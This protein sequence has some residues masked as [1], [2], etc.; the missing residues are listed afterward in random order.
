[1]M[2]G[3]KFRSRFWALLL[4]MAMVFTSGNVPISEVRAEETVSE[5]TKD[6]GFQE[7]SDAPM[8]ES[9][10]KSTEQTA[11]TTE[12][13]SETVLNV[14]EGESTETEAE[15]A[16]QERTTETAEGERT[17]ETVEE[18]A[19][20]IEESVEPATEEQEETE[21]SKE[22]EDQGDSDKSESGKTVTNEFE[23]TGEHGAS[24]DA[25]K[26]EVT[27]FVNKADACYANIK[28]MWYKEYDSYAAAAKEHIKNGG[29]FIAGVGATNLTENADQTKKSVTV[30]VSEG[31]GAILYYINGEAGHDRNQYEHIIVIDPD[32]EPGTVV[33]ETPKKPG[34][35]VAKWWDEKESPNYGK[36]Y[37][38]WAAASEAQ[39]KSWE[40]S[41]DGKQLVTLENKNTSTY[42]AENIYAEG[43]HK[44]A[45]KAV[46]EA[47]TSEAAEAVFTLNA[48]QAGGGSSEEES[49]CIMISE[50]LE[51]ARV[52]EKI[53]LNYADG[54]D[55]SVF[56]DCTVKVNGEDAEGKYTVDSQKH[57]IEFEA[58]LFDDAGVYRILFEKEGYEFSPVYQIVYAADS[59][60]KWDLVWNDEFSGD[61]LDTGKW[62]YQTGNG[63]AYGVSGWGNSEEQIY[64][65]DSNVSVGDGKLTITAKKE[66]DSYTSARLRTVKEEIGA[67]GKAAVGAP[68]KIGTYGR[69][70]S[71][72]KMPEG[73][74][75]WPAFWMLPHDSEYGTWAASGEIDIM[76]A[77]GRLPGEVC[78]TIHYGDKWPNNSSSGK[79]YQFENGE[80]IGQYHIY[81]IEWDPT[82]MRWYVDGELY[83]TVTNWYSVESESGNYPF[84]APFDE[85]FYVLLNMAL[86]GTFD[87]GASS[88][89]V[90]EN[91]VDMDVD[92]VRWYQREGGY[93]DWEITPPATEKDESQT[94]KEL[95]DTADADK[96]F[97]RDNDFS[98]MKVEPYTADGSWD[99]KSGYW[100]PLLIPGNGNGSAEWSKTTK[101]GK[102][103]LKVAVNNVGSQTYSSQMLQY[104]PVVKGYS[105]EISYT[106]YTDAVKQK[107]D[108]SLK[109]GGDGDNGWAV[110]SGNYA[111]SLTTT[112]ATYRHKFTMSAET[113][114][115][116]RFEFNLATSAGNVYL[117]DVYVKLI[118]KI[119]EDEG[120][121]DDKEP[122]ADGNHI[123]NGGFSNGIDSLLYWHWGTA[124][125]KNVVTGV[126]VG[127]ERKAQ[128]KVENNNAVSM[129]QYGLNLLQSDTYVLTFDVDSDAAQDIDLKV[130]DKDGKEVYAE[131][132]KSVPAG[133]SKVKW[134]FVQ[135]EDKTDI[136]G[137]LV[138]TFHCSAKLDNVKLVRTT[139]NNVDYDKVDL[140]PLANG[141]F[142]DGLTGWNIWH[143]GAGWE[144]H[145]VNDQGQLELNQVKIGESATFYCVGIQSPSMSLTKGINYKVKFDY[146]LPAEKTYTLELGGEQREITLQAGTHTYESEVFSGSG[147]GMFALYLGPRQSQEYTLLLD[148]IVVYAD[149]PIKDGYK[150]PVS[151]GQD[152]KAKAGSDVVVKYSGSA[153][154]KSGW[155]EADKKYYLDNVEIAADKVRLETASNRMVIDA[156]LFPDEGV[157]VFWVKA[158]GYTAT[159]V[160]SL[161]VLDASGNLL[162]N[163]NFSDG[164]TGWSF[165][166]ADW[167]SGGSFEVNE[168]G[169]A[170]IEHGYDGG[171]DWHLQLYQDLDY[172]AGDYIVTFDAWAD[173][174]RPV[175]IRLQPDG[176][177]PAFE[178][179][180]SMVVLSTEKKS[181][182]VIWKG[183]AAA[184]AAR[185]DLAMGSMTYD[186]VSA[187]ND[188][189][190]PYKIYLDNIIFRPLTQQDESA[191][192]A[193][194]ASAGAGKAGAEPV[195]VTFTGA[196]DDWKSADKTV[197]VNDIAVDADKVT[198]GGN[199]LVIDASV[200]GEAGRYAVYIAAE[201]FEA[202][203][204]I[205]KNM[206]GADGNRIF[207]GDMNNASLWT[208]YDEDPLNLSRSEIA[209]GVYTLDYTAGYFRDDWNCW[210]TWSSQLKKENISVE[211]GKEYVLRFE[212]STDLE[213][214][215]D[216]LIEYGK[217]GVEGNPQAKAAIRQGEPGIYEVRITPAETRDDF[218]ICY[219]LGPIGDNLQVQGASKV[220]HMLKIDNVTLR[221]AGEDT[222]AAKAQLDACIAEYESLT[223]GDYTD[224]SWSAFEE[225]LAEAKKVQADKDADAA[226]MTDAV[227]RL[228]HAA[229]SLTETSK[230]ADKADKTK[231]AELVQKYAQTEGDDAFKAAYADA[232]KILEDPEASQAEVDAA[233]AKLEAAYRKNVQDKLRACVDQYKDCREEDYTQASW[234]VFWKAYQEAE[235][236][237]ESEDASAEQMQTAME[238]L[239]TAAEGLEPKPAVQVREGLWI[240]TIPDQEY[241]GAA[242]KPEVRVYNGGRL[243]TIKE[244][245]TVSYK[246]NVNAGTALVTVT[247][248]G[249]FTDK[250]TAEFKILKKNLS[251][252]DI[253]AEDV[254]AV[255]AK[256]G[257]VK[258]PKATVKY[259]KKTLSTSKDIMV[260]YPNLPKDGSGNYI[261]GIYQITIKPKDQNSNY[262]GSRVI[263]YE[264]CPRDAML[265]SKARITLSAKKVICQGDK[266]IKPAVTVKFGRVRL[267]QGVDYTVD[268]D[269]WNQSGAASVIVSAVKGSKYYGSRTVRY[270]VEGTRLKASQIELSG[271]ESAYIY[272][273]KPISVSSTL[274]ITDRTSSHMLVEG[275]DYTITYKTG[276][277]AGA[278]TDVGTV[279]VIITGINTYSGTMKRQF[280]ITP[281]DLAS[282]SVALRVDG[283][284]KAIYSKA[285]AKPLFT[286]VLDD[287]ILEEKSDYTVSYTGNTHIQTG[288]KSAVM[289]VK[290]KG[291]FK[292]KIQYSYEV[293]AASAEDV[294]A[295]ASDIVKPMSANRIKTNVKIVEKQTGKALKAGKDYDKVSAYYIDSGC[296]VPVSSESFG[297]LKADDVIYTKIVMKGNYTG[298]GQEA[299]SL[300]VPFRLYDKDKKIS[301]S[302]KFTVKVE[303]GQSNPAIACD[304]KGNPVYTGKAVEPKVTVWSKTDNRLLTEGVDYTVTY[305]NNIRKGKATAVV[306]GIGNGYGGDK[307]IKFKIVSADM[308]WSTRTIQ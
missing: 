287:N 135:P 167:T 130:T 211:A 180:N 140:Y 244:D 228:K 17:T 53:T 90:D 277:K 302:K 92:Y 280:K 93:D 248:K 242:M 21:A 207:G 126:K 19:E 303:A 172:T 243:L 227:N 204:T 164:K 190:S 107:A 158:E 175:N 304:A 178:N 152:G 293:T 193:V 294:T 272:T 308:K 221:E 142:S 16:E 58:G 44:V 11:Q 149:I 66:G 246:N 185:F 203:N 139:Y 154:T 301:D 238:T 156:S 146:T 209:D 256:N 296:T 3:K 89:D 60:D 216:I 305:S 26:K 125:E 75:I 6:T 85:E 155:E 267:I 166:L 101:D 30:S 25:D 38:A 95:L 27:F 206:V 233:G 234:T 83:S 82:A 258:N 285:G 163:G 195:T 147:S 177:S 127:N 278:H 110:Y 108:I 197:Y 87:S 143:E 72:I 105:Y 201:G 182:Q 69:V 271:I 112:P 247:G 12:E 115:T 113:D 34:G 187:P 283:G 262:T 282:P 205:Y 217:P 81:T 119:S 97:I 214:G 14:P 124:D 68:L 123:Y 275:T 186:G 120:E 284:A 295:D 200:F 51:Q 111:D 261:P 36:I 250:D 151:L 281:L 168:N 99:V 70:E 153:Q 131:E 88:I 118:D 183:L 219:L 52:G 224:E 276:K 171:E 297:K 100:A 43:N 179:A 255:I 241:T 176:S 251:D 86:G 62:D 80:S 292:G 289:T 129:W 213:G 274:K 84:P 192:P 116:A 109:I 298:N 260:E 300:A 236:Y 196:G 15:T 288:Q 160:L 239:R 28:T 5:E 299:D 249:N 254:Y 231:L 266:T 57:T 169:T 286:L 71:K 65:R 79:T 96:N 137:R 259:G 141:D 78:G 128:V 257:T 47:G 263:A 212:A 46:N 174:K 37:I 23:A 161:I 1:M 264:V 32:A 235:A 102:N 98:E 230:P 237:A 94:A 91:G 307:S 106:A 162:T 145:K 265:I 49:K 45:L 24:Y 222:A 77:R 148:N 220:P 270:T 273:G 10:V 122:L 269:S 103:Y 20:T 9:A 50:Q 215:R 268:Y 253:T 33:P 67:D 279:S 56:E 73:E 64:T 188:G 252:K 35:L 165:Y 170:V 31:T 226:Q 194:I 54:T 29:N 74:G 40:L 61:A 7:E 232:K 18:T 41:V 144:T 134:E 191:V 114:P 133:A 63:S 173:V 218:Y 208:V 189:S 4:S 55:A 150:Q 290:G 8:T 199:H 225:A 39:V 48:A 121:D 59:E 157:Y 13:S 184:D 138:M 2:R 291:N 76:E 181:Y 210:V 202:T 42:F 117:S 240:D 198:S 104:F 229:E 306:T 22:L 223:Q 132:T 136:S 159:K 245:Y